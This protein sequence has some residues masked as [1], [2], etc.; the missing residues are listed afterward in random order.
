LLSW[1]HLLYLKNKWNNKVSCILFEFQM[2]F[3][4]FFN[5]KLFFTQTIK[6]DFVIQR[7][8]IKTF[9]SPSIDPSYHINEIKWFELGLWC[10]MHF[11]QY[12]SYIV[13]V[14]FNGGGNL[15]TLRKQTI[16]CKSLSYFITY[17]CI[18][19]TSPSAG[20]ELTTLVVIGT[21][22]IGNCKSNYH[23]ITTKMA[24][25]WNWKN[26]LVHDYMSKV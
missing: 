20:F 13:A 25:Q 16:C 9:V 23:T 15:S 24:L 3:W 5:K 21:D 14:I 2:Q 4:I 26:C 1:S 10:L 18:E 22:C 8:W 12:F 6:H 11:Q 19:Y 17:C 7:Y